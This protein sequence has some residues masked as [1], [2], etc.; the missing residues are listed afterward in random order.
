MRVTRSTRVTFPPQ[1]SGWRR[2]FP[3]APEGRRALR[4]VLADDVLGL[5]GGIADLVLDLARCAVDLALVLEVLVVRQVAGG[6]LHTA[7]CLV[8]STVAHPALL[9]SL[10]A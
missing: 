7:L 2:Q 3:A 5:V 9:P 8:G 1:P 10:V 4:S 6:F